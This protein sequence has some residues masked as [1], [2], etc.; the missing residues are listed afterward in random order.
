[1]YVFVAW[2][3]QVSDTEATSPTQSNWLNSE[4]YLYT[5]E[6]KYWNQE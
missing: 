5:P 1:M 4:E 6:E 3:S 2:V